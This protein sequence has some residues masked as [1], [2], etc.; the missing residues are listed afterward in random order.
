MRL[1]SIIISIFVP[2]GLLLAAD[3]KEKAP[4]KTEGYEASIV[5]VKTLSGD[6]FNRLGR[7]LNVFGARYTVDEKL[8]T[9]LI[10]APKDVTAQM[11][12][13]IE[14]LD[15][16]GSEAAIGRNIEMTVTFLRCYTS[17][18]EGTIALPA[19][20]ESVAKQI[21]GATQ[22]KT[23]QL[24]DVVPLHLQEG[25]DARHTFRL[26][27]SPAVPNATSIGTMVIVPEAVT[28]KADGR[29]VRFS[30]LNIN[31]RL[32]YLTNPTPQGQVPPANS[33]INLYQWYEFGLKTAGD[34]KEGQKTVLGKVSGIDDE[35]AI[36]VVIALKIQ[37]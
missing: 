34:F 26:P 16:P 12:R 19:E 6:A 21:R 31:F 1:L 7:M 36:F 28:R 23:V 14:Q 33:G 8:R 15:Q 18:P 13:V 4:E 17:A 2:A 9:I 22:Y 37:D 10:Y 35:S 24:W 20:L 11:R 27:T 29:Y 32:P 30:D 5:V 25:K 3:E